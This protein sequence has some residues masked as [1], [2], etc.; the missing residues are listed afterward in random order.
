M[1]PAMGAITLAH[2]VARHISEETARHCRATYAE[3]MVDS[4]GAGYF[5]FSRTRIISRERVLVVEDVVTTG[6]STRLV[7]E[8]VRA[9][10]ATIVP[11]M[12]TLVSR[13]DATHIDEMEI[14]CLTDFHPSTWSEGDCPLCE[15]GSEALRPKTNWDTMI[16]SR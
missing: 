7:V 3:K 13:T 9:F 16:K 1:G 6:K 14:V 15:Q 8:A 5:A 10:G 11:Y 2:D 4:E 12:G